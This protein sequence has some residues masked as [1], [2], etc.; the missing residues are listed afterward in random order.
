MLN[1]YHYLQLLVGLILYTRR[2]KALKAKDI[3]QLAPD[4]CFKADDWSGILCQ[5]PFYR[6]LL[7]VPDGV[8][9]EFAKIYGTAASSVEERTAGTSG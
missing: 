5:D 8:V 3:Y 6:F 1:R 9:I 4:L 2:L 7:S